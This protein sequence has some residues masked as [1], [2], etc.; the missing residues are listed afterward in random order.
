ML[1]LYRSLTTGTGVIITFTSRGTQYAHVVDRRGYL[2]NGEKTKG[3]R[4]WRRNRG[5]WTKARALMPGELVRLATAADV[6][7]FAPDFGP[8][9]D[10]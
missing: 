8:A 1:D 9:W 3:V 6:A 5:K 7:K 2:P 4:I 10:R